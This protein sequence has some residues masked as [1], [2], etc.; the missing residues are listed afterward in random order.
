[1]NEDTH[2]AWRSRADINDFEAMNG[3]YREYFPTNKPARSTFGSN[4]LVRGARVEI[5]CIAVLR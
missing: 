5:E 2:D 3:V 1:M 4:G